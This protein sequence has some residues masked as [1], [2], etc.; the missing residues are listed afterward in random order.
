MVHLGSPHWAADLAK[1]LKVT[2]YDVPRTLGLM[3]EQMSG[4]L[5]QSIADQVY[6]PLAPSTIA[7]KGFATTLEDTSVMINSVKAEVRT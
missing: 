6:A 5:V 7:R 1:L 4:E 3:G 2:G